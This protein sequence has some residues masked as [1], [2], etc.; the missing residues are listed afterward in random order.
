MPES[1]LFREIS[2]LSTEQNNPATENIDKADISGILELIAA[3]D[4][5]VPAAVRAELPHLEAAV[6]H[7]VQAFRQGGRLFY[8]G[9]G[10]SGRLGVVDASECPPTFGTAPEIVQGIIAGGR[11]AMFRAQEGAEDS[12]ENGAAEVRRLGIKPPDV[13]CGIAASGRTPFVK[14]ALSEAFDKGVYTVLVTTAPEDNVRE[15][16]MKAHTYICPQVGPEVIAGSTRMKSGT[17]QKLVL[18]MLTTASMIRMGKT[19]GN[20]MVDLQMTNAKLK[21]RAKKI[22]MR[23]AGAD[24]D[25]AE[26][27]LEKSGWN[28]KIA[29][30]MMLAGKT[31][32]EALLLLD[33]SDGFVKIAIEK[34]KNI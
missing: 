17:A 3:E 33:E 32:E 34:A 24:Y 31:R 2:S 11:D 7:I 25:Q 30:V 15:L 28:V 4:A 14:G 23:L 9:A 5:R 18:N 13:L 27:C 20:V 16:G 6:E 19:L 10:T 12:E 8:F 21:E 22:V 1:N 26:A 29:L